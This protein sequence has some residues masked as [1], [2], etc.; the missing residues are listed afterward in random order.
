MWRRNIVIKIK[1]KRVAES[2]EL[3]KCQEKSL[4]VKEQWEKMLRLRKLRE[5]N[6]NFEEIVEN[7]VR[8]EKNCYN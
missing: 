8:T 4:K 2:L 3:R 1:V 6:I 5:K 7:V